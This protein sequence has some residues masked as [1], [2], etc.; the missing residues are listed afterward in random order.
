MNSEDLAISPSSSTQVNENF[1]SWLLNVVTRNLKIS[2]GGSL[3]LDGNPNGYEVSE[4]KA[5]KVELNRR[6]IS[7]LK[8]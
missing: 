5:T 3:L 4:H 1:L 7:T 2:R 6:I 8:K